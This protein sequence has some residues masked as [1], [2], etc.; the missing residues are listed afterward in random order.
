MKTTSSSVALKLLIHI[1]IV[2]GVSTIQTSVIAREFNKIRVEIVDNQL[3]CSDY[4]GKEYVGSAVD[5]WRAV[6]ERSLIKYEL[7]TIKT[8][9]DAVKL[10][11]DRAT[12]IAIS[13]LNII[14]QRLNRV[15]F[16]VPYQFDSLAFL[17]KAKENVKLIDIFQKIVSSKIIITSL[18]LLYSITFIASIVLWKISN[19]F[20]NKDV[21]CEKTTHTFLKGWMMLAMGGGI[22]KLADRP[23]NM[24]II[25]IINILRLVISSILVGSIASIIFDQRT[26]EDGNSDV[27]LQK[28]IENIVGVGKGTISELWIA[29]E[30]IK[31]H[32]NPEN[33]I[34]PISG[35]DSL[36]E[37]LKTGKVGSILADKQRII[38]LDKKIGK[39]EK[40][41]VAANTFNETPQGFVFGRDLTDKERKK[42]NIEIANLM[43]SG[44][45]EAIRKRW[46]Q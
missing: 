13:C 10:A 30:A 4:N 3:P 21:E 43:F 41:H 14:P 2:T 15:Q 42:I 17:S 16:S 12:D 33:Y 20:K 46:K 26:P 18:L 8:P 38:M 28:T 22:Y 7:H 23:Q 31:I 32:N 19:G 9:N 34:I 25:T 36:L 44:E 24:S 1:F 27:F 37:S 40:F 35:D 29:N 45:V 39:N 11:K 5:L 6:A